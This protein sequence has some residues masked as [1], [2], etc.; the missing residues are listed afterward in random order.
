M[1]ISVKI[2]NVEI[3]IEEQASSDRTAAIRYGDQNEQI[4]K[5]IRVMA[6]ECIKLQ[7]VSRSTPTTQEKA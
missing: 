6:D 4:Q 5:T 3:V 1:K 7:N 2:D